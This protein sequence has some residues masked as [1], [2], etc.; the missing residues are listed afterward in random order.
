MTREEII[1]A[2]PLVEY[3]EKIGLEMR[4]E[5]HEWV[6]LCPLHD[7][8]TPSFKINAEKQVFHCFGCGAGGSVIDLHMGM[9]GLSNGEAMREL[10]SNGNVANVGQFQ[11]QPL[12]EWSESALL[13]RCR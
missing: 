9:R 3:C 1:T 6:C 4:R 10:S 2:N 12:R 13:P 7:D 11:Q 5:G 8:R